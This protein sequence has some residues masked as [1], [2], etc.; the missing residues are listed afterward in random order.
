MNPILRNILAVVAG[1]IAGSAVNMGIIMLSSSIIPPRKE[2]MS[3]TWR[4]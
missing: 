4:A 3:P 2:W 1:I